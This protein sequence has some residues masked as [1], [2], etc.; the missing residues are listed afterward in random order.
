[1]RHILLKSVSTRL[2]TMK[3][4]TV[5]VGLVLLG[6]VAVTQAASA[7]GQCRF[8]G[9]PLEASNIRL[10]ALR[11]GFRRPVA[12]KFIPGFTDRYYVVEQGGLLKLVIG[13]QI[14]DTPSLDLSGMID[15]EDNETGF[16]GF[17]FHPQFVT[18]RRVFINY[19]TN[20]VLTT[21]I[22]E[23]RVGND[24]RV[25]PASERVLLSVR[26]P[27]SNHNGGD[28][29]F[30]P[31]GYL[32]FGLG[33]GGSANDPSGNGQNLKVFLAKMLRIDVDH[34]NP[35]AIPPTNPTWSDPLAKREIFAYGLRNPWRF[36]FDRV[37]GELWVGDVGQN[38]YEEIDI[39]RNGGNYGWRTME[40]NH[41]FRPA[42]NCNRTGLTPPIFEYPRSQGASITGGYVYRG[43]AIPDLIGSYIYA[44]YV[45]GNLWALR[46]DGTRVTSNRLLLQT[47]IEISSFGEDQ[48]GELYALDH[49]GGVINKI[50]AST[51][52]GTPDTFPRR[53]SATG[54]FSSLAPLR[55]AAGVVPYDVVS[56]LWSDGASKDRYI[57]VPNT[58]GV[59]FSSTSP[60]LFPEDTVL[61]KTFSLPQRNAAAPKKMETRFLV[62]KP[63]G[64]KG[65]TYRWN[66]AGT[67]ADL[68]TGALF[69]PATIFANNQD[70]RFDYYFPSS[71]DCQRCHNP[72]TA[73]ALGFDLYHL[74]HDSTA[75]GATQNQVL[76]LA[77]QH[78]FRGSE[79]EI[80]SAVSLA[81]LPNLVDPQDAT[82]PLDQRA[83][84]YL[85]TQCSHCHNPSN[86]AQQG[87]MDLRL[88]A[89]LADMHICDA[90]PT[91]GDL[92]IANAK[93]LKP[94][95]P[96]ASL[97]WARLAPADRQK[98]MP[99]LATSRLD[100]A[101]SE[102]LRSWI[103][104]LRSCQ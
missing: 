53:L 98:K 72:S 102:L 7:A 50:V 48:D 54:C 5:A 17:E 73:G 61:I 95:Q 92:G 45:S 24:L 13:N 77:A 85:H 39:V 76:T 9:E 86:A 70:E 8:Q 15:A 71:A 89:S 90:A 2:N 44:D 81:Q 67:D 74:N 27:F 20:G 96:A 47:G 56:P 68:L 57:Y 59:D 31:D 83:R 26:Q 63:E 55:V 29:H 88:S 3:K 80:G 58:A 21:H 41:C 51:A 30:G 22:S 62:K 49:T 69:V 33:D 46:Y 40:A 32:Y 104:S 12:I 36:S 101:G 6:T 28:L 93:I 43:R 37:T 52:V 94:G 84:S 75:G 42:A 91:Q 35:Y 100:Q 79:T 97:L 1:M 87:N 66:D 38:A 25:D 78:V 18:N 82:Q 4:L 60:W 11:S 99:P 23:F 10:Q 103:S 34:G 16:L 64:F 14:Q 65:Y 19:T